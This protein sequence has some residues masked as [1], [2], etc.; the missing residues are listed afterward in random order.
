MWKMERKKGERTS[1]NGCSRNKRQQEHDWRMLKYMQTETHWNNELEVEGEKKNWTN[2]I[3]K[4]CD[5]KNAHK[6]NCFR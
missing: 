5:D 4:N 6:K 2:E 3:K 1:N